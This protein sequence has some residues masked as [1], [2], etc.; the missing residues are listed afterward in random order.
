[1][2]V[3]VC[4]CVCVGAQPPSALSYIHPVLHQSNLLVQSPQRPEEGVGLLELELQAVVNC[5]MWMLES[6]L[7]TSRTTAGSLVAEASR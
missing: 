7:G 3:C 6:E 4:V 1:V 2:C 5:L